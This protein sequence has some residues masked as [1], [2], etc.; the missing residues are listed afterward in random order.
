M[1]GWATKIG[2]I[3]ILVCALPHFAVAQP[4]APPPITGSPAAETF[5]V[6]IRTGDHPGFGRVVFDLPS[7]VRFAVSSSEERVA[8]RFSSAAGSVVLGSVGRVP[9]NVQALQRGGDRVEIVP[10]RGATIRTSQLASRL[11]FD[12]LDGPK[13]QGVARTTAG[14]EPASPSKPATIKAVPTRDGDVGPAA[15]LIA[16]NQSPDA[17]WRSIEAAQTGTEIVVPRGAAMAA[18]TGVS[19]TNPNSPTVGLAA[20]VEPASLP[21]A[22]EV[23]R[24]ITLPFGPSVGAAAVRR[25]SVALVV[26]DDR[27]PIDLGSLRGDPVFDGASIS[28]LPTATVLTLPVGADQSLRLHKAPSG[29]TIKVHGRG[30]SPGDL[31]PISPERADGALR[32]PA[33]APGQVVS[34]PDP[35][36]GGSILVGTQRA[37]GQA[38]PMDRRTP[39]FSLLPT[40][41]GVA[42][43]PLSDALTLRPNANGFVLAPDG[44]RALA[45]SATESQTREMTEAAQASRR[46]D[47]PAMSVE[48]LHRRLQSTLRAAATSAPQARANRRREVAEAMLSLGMGAEMH[49]VL[50]LARVEDGRA[51]SDPDVVGLA[52]IAA[53]LAGRRGESAGI[54]DARL[55]GTDEIALWRA[56]RQAMDE[57]AS[58]RAAALFASAMPLLLSYPEPLRD[59]LLPIALETMAQ[60]GESSTAQ[61][62]LERFGT[63]P[64]LDLARGLVAEHSERE[65]SA[66]LA[67]YD[68]VAAS[69]DRRAR[70]RAARRAIEL[71]LANGLLSAQQAADAMEKLVYSWRG[72]ELEFETRT[73]IAALRAQSGAWR[74]AMAL[75]RETRELYPEHDAALRPQLVDIFTRSLSEDSLAPMSPID[76]VALTQENS[77]LIPA[78][79]EGIRLASQ[80]AERWMA[81]ELPDRAQVVLEKLAQDAPPGATRALF[82]AKLAALRLQQ[83]DSAGAL[84]A[85][86]ST[87]SEG[88]LP[89]ALLEA[90]TLTFARASSAV[91]NRDAA[92]QTLRDLATPAAHELSATLLEEIRDWRGATQALSSLLDAT[93]PAGGPISDTQAQLVLRLASAASQAG[94]ER[95][96]ASLRANQAERLPEGALSDLF[97]LLTATAVQGVADLPRASREIQLA[98]DLPE[99]LRRMSPTR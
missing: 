35:L 54:E 17:R 88:P 15:R 7:T 8:V 20:V 12:V 41:Q 6:G 45:L 1:C 26:F 48:G 87:V 68:R 46:Y 28:V 3:G 89:P 23:S 72:D 97:R 78:G 77:D 2:R 42:V 33:E 85:L 57:P 70:A 65:P 32:L 59:R 40:W 61:R 75:L 71:R 56:V 92:V 5:A 49:A 37:D 79:Q 19:S 86:A 44:D 90:R 99:G 94:D 74:P 36:T 47:L 60:G 81:L 69:S 53:L 27:R 43:V 83:G 31:R 4:E 93:L 80:L 73:R 16:P 22:S 84:Q 34:V 11:I 96:L 76:L 14:N 25:G 67:I 50:A 18:G 39:E 9:R 30:Q 51:A 29:W 82:G 64:S 38:S 63:A 98:R 55:T 52:A 66:A 95:T 24:A 10:V 62:V 58:P 21:P 91:G 13:P